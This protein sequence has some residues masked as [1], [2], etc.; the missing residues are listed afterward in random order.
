[1]ESKCV[2]SCFTAI[3]SLSEASSRRNYER[4]I[5][6]YSMSDS[7]SQLSAR[8]EPSPLARVASAALP[9][10]PISRHSFLVNVVSYILRPIIRLYMHD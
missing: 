5:E 10:P 7:H 8:V 3:Q 2:Y 9:I 1:M 4:A 6:T